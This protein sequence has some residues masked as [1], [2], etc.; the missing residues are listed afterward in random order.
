V[1]SPHQFV[2]VVDDD[3]AVCRA[4]K[5]SLR[6][7]G[8]EAETFNSGE[9]FLDMLSSADSSLPGCLIVDS[10]MPGMGGL[11]LQRQLAPTGVPIIFIAATLDEAVR[12]KALARGAAEYLKKPVDSAL[13]ISTVRMA[14]VLPHVPP[15]DS[16][17]EPRKEPEVIGIGQTDE[18]VPIDFSCDWRAEI[19]VQVLEE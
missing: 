11:E 14:L 16:P 15:S 17:W 8:I 12:G 6:S 3:D 5:R 13:L 18:A 9:A 1:G 19:K 2:A 4:L 7:A 10:L